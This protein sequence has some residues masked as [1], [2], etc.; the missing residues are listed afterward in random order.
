[1]M[2]RPDPAALLQGPLGSWLD[3]QAVVRDQARVEANERL[4]KAALFGGVPAAFL[5]FLLPWPVDFKM[6]VLVMIMNQDGMPMKHLKP[7]TTV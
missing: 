6:M 1:M 7:L 5:M 2:N 3:Q 4:Y